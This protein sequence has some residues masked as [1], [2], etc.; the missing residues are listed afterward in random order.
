MPYFYKV[1]P[2]L[3]SNQDNLL[4]YPWG[5]IVQTRNNISEIWIA[6]KGSN[7]VTH[8]D[9]H[10]KKTLANPVVNV[11][12]AVLDGN[13]G[14]TGIVYNTTQGFVITKNSVSAPSLLIVCTTDGQILGWNPAVDPNFVQAFYDPT[15]NYTGLEINGNFIYA[16]NFAENRVDTF[17]NVFAIQTQAFIDYHPEI[18][19]PYNIR[20][21]G[22]EFFVAYAFN[23]GSNIPMFGPGF[24]IINVFDTNGAMIRRLVN[25]PIDN[26]DTGLN[27]PW[28][29]TWIP[30]HFTFPETD[31]ILIGSHG[32]GTIQQRQDVSGFFEK[33]LKDNHGEPISIEKIRSLVAFGD[34][35]F[36]TQDGNSVNSGSFGF[37]SRVSTD[38]RPNPPCPQPK[39]PCPKPKPPCPCEK[40]KP[41]CGCH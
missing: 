2:L 36:Y 38:C 41:P 9:I 5:M 34:L 33:Y 16:T 12:P 21:I 26:A 28:G 40:P 37:I 17:N 30:N 1:N 19:S 14:P 18:Y 8:Y 15:A 24:G 31:T 29:L 20:F 3:T 23:N 10:G 35:L 13:A 32:N 39:P 11:P 4:V 22:G 7:A 25:G 27:A 6:D